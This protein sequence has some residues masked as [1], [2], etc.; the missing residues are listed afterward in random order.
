[1]TIYYITRETRPQI[2]SLFKKHNLTLREITDYTLYHNYCVVHARKGSLFYLS[3]DAEFYDLILFDLLAKED[4]HVIVEAHHS[5]NITSL[6]KKQNIIFLPYPCSKELLEVAIE[7]FM[8][9]ARVRTKPETFWGRTERM[10]EIKEMIPRISTT[11]ASIHIQ[12]DL[13]SGKNTIVEEIA[14]CAG[15]GNPL[16]LNCASINPQLI[17]DELFGHVKGAY[18]SADKDR[19]GICK[20]ADNGIL[21]L[22][23]IQD[24]SNDIQGKLLHL[25]ETGFYKP[26]GSDEEKRSDFKLITASSIPYKELQNIMRKDFLSRI[27]TIILDVPSL[28]ERKNDLTEFIKH[29]AKYYKYRNIPDDNEIKA[30]EEYDWPGNIRELKKC[31]E[32]YDC[33]RRLPGYIQEGRKR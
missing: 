3:E 16:Y 21:F 23:E 27:G 5:S 2:R 18:T 4:C 20:R 6:I 30:M 1:M 24:I 14:D 28:H 12:G 22:D 19:D 7:V 32:Y 10:Q 8:Q 31:L 17:E 29:L 33:L 11:R 15:M 9:K 25:L 13:G 26:I